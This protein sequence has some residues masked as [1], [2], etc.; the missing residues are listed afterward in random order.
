MPY[1]ELNHSLP[2]TDA[3]KKILAETITA[4]H[5][6]AFDTPSMFVNIRFVK[7]DLTQGNIFVA[8]KRD[9]GVS[10][11]ITS[12]V[13]TSDARTKED[14]DK[15]TNEIEDA[16]Y[17]IVGKGP[18]SPD[19]QHPYLSEAPETRLHAIALLP[20]V[21]AREAG[22]A[23]PVAGEEKEWIGKQLPIFKKLAAHGNAAFVTLL[24]ELQ[25]KKG[26]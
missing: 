12:Y 25:A 8:G 1:Y 22:F 6:K 7:E 19:A 2:L 14:F 18:R 9:D 3:Q 10:N 23:I 15:V 24:N 17:A 20:I 16:W 21:T 13:R 11:S 4:I 26:Q 5:C